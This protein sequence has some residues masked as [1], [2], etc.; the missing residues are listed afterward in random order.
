MVF[1][2]VRTVSLNSTTTGGQVSTQWLIL[3]GAIEGVVGKLPIYRLSVG[4]MSIANPTYT[5]IIVGCLPA[6]AIFIRGRVTA[7]RVQ[8]YGSY[9]PVSGPSTNDR[10]LKSSRQKSKIRTES[11]QLDDMG[12]GETHMDSSMM[13]G[14][15]KKSLVNET[16]DGQI[17]VQHRWTQKWHNGTME[18]AERQRFEKLGFGNGV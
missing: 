3:W 4:V 17:L 12:E 2:T 1:A 8:N 14:E 6:F 16:M 18:D 7:S 5:A 13:D 11:M 10:S 15:S 9:P